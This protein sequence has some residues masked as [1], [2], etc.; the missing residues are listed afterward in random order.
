MD[1]SILRIEINKLRTEIEKENFTIEELTNVWRNSSDKKERISI[2]EAITA[3]EKNI[4]SKE[5]NIN[6]M[7][8]QLNPGMVKQMISSTI[9]PNISFP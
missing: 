8:R 7:L 1:P 3:I 5:N 9:P 6:E 4:T 2:L